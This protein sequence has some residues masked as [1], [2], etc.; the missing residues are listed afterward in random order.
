MNNVINLADYRKAKRKPPLAWTE[1]FVVSDRNLDI[2]ATLPEGEAITGL[3]S[4]NETGGLYVTTESGNAYEISG[5][6]EVT[7]ISCEDV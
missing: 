3:A 7:K 5:K 4:S 2:F 1:K 6:G